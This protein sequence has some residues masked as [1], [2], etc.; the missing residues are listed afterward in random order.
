MYGLESLYRLA[1]VTPGTPAPMML[2]PLG[3][4]SSKDYPS[5]TL[6]QD[7]A[8]QVIANF[9]SEVLRT[10]V[11]V[12]SVGAHDAAAPAGGWIER[13][14]MAP[15][16]WQ[17][18]SGEALYA[19]WTPNERGAQLVN[20]G[21]F[22]YDSVEI[23]THRDPVT[24]AETPNVLKAVAL[25]NRPVLRMMPPVAEAGDSI[26]LAEPLS[27]A[28]SEI[29]LA[30]PDPVATLLD[31][32]DELAARL[33]EALK[34]KRGMPTV[35][36]LLR[37]VRAKAASHTLAEGDEQ[38]GTTLDSPVEVQREAPVAAADS[39]PA[40]AQTPSSQAVAQGEACEGDGMRLAEGD[41]ATKGVDPEMKAIIRRLKLAEDADETAVL[42]AVEL[43]FGERESARTRADAAEKELAENVK[44]AALAAFT[45]KLD[46]KIEKEGTIAPG[47]RDFYLSEAERDVAHADM[48]IACRTHKIIDFAERG[49]ASRGTERPAKRADVEL[50]EKT[51][52][53]MTRDG[54]DY[55]RAM[56]LVLSEDPD[57]AERYEAFTK[58]KEG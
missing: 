49:A 16:E 6:G 15:F 12:E 38:D 11:P 20:D 37:E 33:D 43:L 41:A 51:R 29:T 31:D 3:D 45:T 27:I 50:S 13:L 48:A 58:G 35:R 42:A 57:L 17:G 19:D 21:Q 55:P 8:D 53:R 47:E 32:M 39:S 4:W 46:E 10:K 7:L 40:G 9:E 52:A 28:L 56:G 23:D 18:I 26:R 54:I 25:T 30:A 22:A 14:Y 36:T 5:L 44:A 1:E 2:F 24:G 34:G